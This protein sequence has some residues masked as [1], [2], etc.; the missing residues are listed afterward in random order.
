MNCSFATPQTYCFTSG[1]TG[2]M[3]WD[4][5]EDHH[6]EEHQA[7]LPR[8]SPPTDC[9]LAVSASKS[10][11]ATTKWRC[12]DVKLEI[13]L[14]SGSSVS[15]VQQKVPVRQRELLSTHFH[16]IFNW[17]QNQAIRYQYLVMFLPQYA[18]VSLKV[19]HN[20]VVVDSLIMPVILGVN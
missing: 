13:M 3:A 10:K 16:S 17:S 1:Q 12:G 14:D 6:H 19:T 8:V 18:L 4:Y 20:F 9:V 15:L 11:E 2:H 7:L 5:Q